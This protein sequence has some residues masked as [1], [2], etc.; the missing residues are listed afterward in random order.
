MMQGIAALEQIAD[1]MPHFEIINGRRIFYVDGLP[2]T[3]LTAEIPWWD[4]IWGRHQ[5]TMHVYD[6]LYPAAADMG[7]N[8]LKVPVKWSIVEPEAGV[9]DFAYVDHILKMARKNNLKVILGWFGH[10]ASGDGNIYRNLSN[11]V[12]AP[13][14]VIEDDQTYPRAVD[15]DGI[16]HHNSAAY[17]YQAIVEVETRAFCAFIDHIRRIDEGT[18]TVIMIQVENEIAVFGY[19]RQNRKMW[20]DHSPAANDAFKAGSF[21]DDL[22]YSAWSMTTKWLRPLTDAGKAIYPLPFFVNFVGGQLTDW[23]V[24]GSPGEDVRTYLENCPAIDFCGLNLYVQPGRSI[25]DLRG[26]LLNYQTGRNMPSITEANS[27]L[28]QMAPRMAFVSIGEF[29]APIFAPWALN[30]SYP[31]PYQPYVKADGTIANGGPE[32]RDCYRT[33]QNMLVPVS[34]YGGTTNIKVFMSVQPG[35]KFADTR[36]MGGRKIFV[37]GQDNG[38]AI[39]IHTGG[40]EYIAA[41]YRCSI[42]IETTKAIWPDLKEIEV[43]NGRWQGSQW[44]AEAETHY[45]I[46][47]SSSQIGVS[48]GSPMVL[49]LKV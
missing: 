47:Q 38:Q 48:L 49:R 42:S 11:E 27:D 16:T 28:S 25:N 21:R 1:R 34:F 40:N 36:D 17:D 8:T 35:H 6:Y 46:N 41:G 37:E 44:I 19:E 3:S 29:G 4:I 12:F 9:Y 7:L 10:Y 26:A 15:A 31:A 2:F 22:H 24:G 23:M 13:M 33:L 32:L 45:T 5:E 18:H 30:V 20:R 14:Y 39:I 43:E